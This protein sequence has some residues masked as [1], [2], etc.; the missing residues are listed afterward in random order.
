MRPRKIVHAVDPDALVVGMDDTEQKF[1]I[2]PPDEGVST[3]D[4]GAR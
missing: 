4:P 1:R 3:G 2:W